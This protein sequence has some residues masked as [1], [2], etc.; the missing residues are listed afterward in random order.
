MK[1]DTAL[2]KQRL[3]GVGVLMILF[4]AVAGALA[5]VA[6]G[7]EGLGDTNIPPP[8]R[9]PV[10]QVLPFDERAAAAEAALQT[11]APDA[12]PPAPA[13]KLPEAQAQLPAAAPSQRGAQGAATTEQARSSAK[14]PSPKEQA[15]PAKAAAGPSDSAVPSGSP[16]RQQA[17]VSPNATSRPG[18]GPMAQ[19]WI[20]QLGSFATEA[21][22][23]NLRDQVRARGAAAFIEQG[24]GVF[25]VRIGP[26]V[27]RAEADRIREDVAQNVKVAGMVLSYP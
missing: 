20:V 10:T 13:A 15:R 26:F 19:S 25:R 7:G 9:P 23:R 24:G 16:P 4:G 22:A 8:P 12:A 18:D 14:T 17:L 21:N 5:F 2:W 11:H 1:L 6:G 27:T 3:T